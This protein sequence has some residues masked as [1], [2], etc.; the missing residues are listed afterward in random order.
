[1]K[2]IEAMTPITLN[3][4]RP[5]AGKTFNTVK[6]YAAKTAAGITATART[7]LPYFPKAAKRVISARSFWL[8]AA[9]LAGVVL[10]TFGISMWSIPAAIIIGGLVLV[11]IVEVR[12]HVGQRLPNIPPPVE[13]LRTQAESAAV[14]IN[15]DRYGLGAVDT[16]RLADLTPAECERLIMAARAIGASKT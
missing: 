15:S 10:V 16:S 6:P 14:V 3:K 4:L 8:F 2:V 12:P 1:M 13:L 7:A 11:G 9:E 5:Y